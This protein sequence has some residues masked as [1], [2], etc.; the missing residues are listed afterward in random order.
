MNTLLS[1]AFLDYLKECYDEM[2]GVG[3]SESVNEAL[4]PTTVKYFGTNAMVN[5]SVYTAVVIIGAML[6]FA[7]I[8]RVFVI[9]KFSND[10]PGKLQ[11]LLESFVGYFDK[12]SRESVHSQANFVGPYAL[13]ASA[14]IALTTL[15]ELFGLRPAMADVNMCLSMGLTTFLIINI[16]GFRKKGFVGRLKRFSNPIN[17]ITDLSVPLSL[18]FRLFGSIT[19]GFIIMELVHSMIFT[20]FV[21]PAGVSVITTFFH[22]AI[23]SYLFG[24]LTNVFVSEAIE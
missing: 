21:I 23:Q 3:M 2:F 19:S 15:A 7:L 16:C 14:F 12:S 4:L 10:N 22:A 9:P 1:G 8:V 11:I 5:P 24:T 17:I 20:V 6:L 13:T 18:S